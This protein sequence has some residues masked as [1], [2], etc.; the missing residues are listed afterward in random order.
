MKRKIALFA[1]AVMLVLSVLACGISTPAPTAQP[2]PQPPVSSPTPVI[3]PSPDTSNELAV[4]DT[5]SF[6]DSS[7]AYYIVGNIRNGTDTALSGIELDIEVLDA[8]GNSIFTDDSGNL[9]SYQTTS[10]LLNTLAPGEESPFSYYFYLESGKTPD[11][12]YV[13]IAA[14]STTQIDRANVAVENAQFINDGNGTLYISGELVNQSDQWAKIDTLA[15]AALDSEQLIVSADWT[16]NFSAL[17]APAGDASGLDRTPFALDIT[18]PGDQPA[19]WRVY[20]DAELTDAP[21]DYSLVVDSSYTYADEYGDFHIV[22]TITNNSQETLQSLVMAGLYDADGITLD[23]DYTFVSVAILPG[24][25]IPWD[26]SS[27]S[28]VNSSDSEAARVDTFTYQVDMY[29][30]Y[31]TS[32]EYV[33]LASTGDQNQKNGSTVTY[34]GT[35]TNTSA[36]NLT[37]ETVIV[38]VNDSNGKLV[39]T[40]N[41]TI[42][43]A[44]NATVIAPNGALTYEVTIY[45]D[46]SLPADATY[47]FKTIVRGT[48]G[49]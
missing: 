28:S 16:M 5:Y 33:S 39:A 35:V 12:Y 41:T 6:V 11:T 7:E 19:N 32:T 44:E 21:T 25:V 34:T 46:P 9:V 47:Q 40:S 15:G 43:P 45:M 8:A 2:S 48:V 27:F 10:P 14:S 20:V 30:T 29:S 17:L 49:E 22:G 18:D 31:S 36:K 37:S 4:T 13:T 42:Y 3:V 38:Y 24:D 23:A 26:I 1:A